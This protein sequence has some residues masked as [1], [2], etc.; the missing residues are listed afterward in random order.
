MRLPRTT[1]NDK[2][3]A[4][5]TIW[6]VTSSTLHYG[7]LALHFKRLVG[8]ALVVPRIWLTLSINKRLMFKN[9]SAMSNQNWCQTA[10][11]ECPLRNP[12]RWDV[13]TDCK[14]S[15]NRNLTFFTKQGS[16]VNVLAHT[17]FS[18]SGKGMQPISGSPYTEVEHLSTYLAKWCACH[19]M[20]LSKL[21]WA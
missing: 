6:L 16:W 3:S 11:N 17:T 15:N 1:E 20:M 18:A 9:D 7:N 4:A 13:G 5:F 19:L 10:L 8:I 2:H 21:G 12:S 14:L